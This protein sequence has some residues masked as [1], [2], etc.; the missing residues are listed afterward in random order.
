MNP[1][2]LLGRAV[3]TS[4]AIALSERLAAWHDGMVSHQR[5]LRA[6]RGVDVC[7][8][9]CPHAEA[10]VLWAETVT[11]FGERASE[12]AFLRSC[13][14][15]APHQPQ[16]SA[17]GVRETRTCDAE[18]ETRALAHRNRATGAPR[19][20]G[21]AD[22]QAVGHGVLIGDHVPGRVNAGRAPRVAHGI[23]A[24]GFEGGQ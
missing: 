18:I 11:M 14:V 15:N 16:E 22:S 3:G 12:L 2:A 23:S 7:H 6:G 24:T 19:R 13:A 5:R 8:E 9:D 10:R 21:S 20:E 4:E 17:G 1:Y